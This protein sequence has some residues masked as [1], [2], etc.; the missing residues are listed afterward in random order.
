MTNT[1]G[2]K[3]ALV[4]GA[5]TGLGF[6]T[7]KFLAEK[8]IQVI[9]ACRNID[10]AKEAKQKIVNVYPKANLVILP[11]DLASLSSVNEFAE[12]VKQNFSHLDILVNNAGLMFPPYEK[13]EDGFELQFGINYLGHFLLTGL[14]IELLEKSA[15]GGRVV[16]LSSLAHKWGDIYFEDLQFEKEYDKQKAY[17]Q[18]KL[19]CLMF[20][21]ELDR[22]LKKTNSSILSVVAH[23]GL[24]RTGLFQYLS[25][26]YKIFI[27][28]VYP[29]T[30]SAACGAQSQIKAA[31]DKSLIGGEY[32]GPS[33][34]QEFSGD[35]TIVSSNY[36]SKDEVKAKRLW[37]IS[38]K[39]VGINYL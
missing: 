17:G 14:L 1:T 36:I 31:L 22:R 5:N 26:F 18:S 23:P 25:G 34:F 21:Y 24:S 10:K 16:N 2:N 35:P 15:F 32:I 13:T 37:K 30:Q 28:F 8:G 20:A 19:A 29:F 7:T 33:G 39:L 4:T 27:P 11:L 9:M 38:E 6:E 3:I 12:E